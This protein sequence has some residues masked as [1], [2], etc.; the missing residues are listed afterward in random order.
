MSKLSK[1]EPRLLSLDQS[2]RKTGWGCFEGS[3]L[4]AWG[5]IDKSDIINSDERIREMTAEVCKLMEHYS[6]ASIVLEDVQQQASPSTTIMLARL[7]GHIMHACDMRGVP[8]FTYKSTAWRK[9]LKFHQG[10]AKR[11]ELKAQA[12]EYIKKCYG[13][14]LGEDV[15]EALCIGLSHLKR[16]GVLPELP[17][18]DFKESK[19]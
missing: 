10:A 6:P 2:T 4:I 18:H 7:Q 14:T 9:V 16:K 1:R 5:V 11:E 19:R 8:F 12:M 15:C 3:D 17:V 13:L